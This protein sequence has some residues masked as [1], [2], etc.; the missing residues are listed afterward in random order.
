MNSVFHF[1]PADKISYYSKVNTLPVDYFIF[2]LEDAVS[3]NNKSLARRLLYAFLNKNK[4]ENFFVRINQLNSVF[5]KD[6][7]KLINKI[8]NLN[9]IVPKCETKNDIF[10]VKKET[11]VSLVLPLIESFKG[12]L[13][14]FFE[15][16]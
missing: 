5:Y 2:D 9:I 12:Y 10:S 15:T 1:I 13:Y 7:I 4:S 16:L 3:K 6:D 11:G 8:G 14:Q